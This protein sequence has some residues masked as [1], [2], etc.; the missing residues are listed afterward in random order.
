VKIRKHPRYK[1]VKNIPVRRGGKT[2]GE[3]KRKQQNYK[4]REST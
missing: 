1:K 4:E 2:K 3:K